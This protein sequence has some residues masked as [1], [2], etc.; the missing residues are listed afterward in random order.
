MI[1][2]KTG[3]ASAVS[4]IIPE[5]AGKFDGMSVRVPTPNVSLVDLVVNL[6]QDVTAPEINDL[7]RSSQSRYLAYTE[8]PLVSTDLLKDPHSGIVDGLC[9]KVIDRRM[10]KVV[11]WYDNEWGYSNR[12]LDL[13]VHMDRCQAF[14]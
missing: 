2:T 3:A 4:K 11:I 5:L 9:T 12:V 10:A 7:L 8:E 1:P 6:Q 13:I 14:K